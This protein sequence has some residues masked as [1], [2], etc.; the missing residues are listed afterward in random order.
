MSVDYV[1]EVVRK[2]VWD[3]FEF[4]WVVKRS[5]EQLILLDTSD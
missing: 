5:R 2:E 1:V 4:G 3:G